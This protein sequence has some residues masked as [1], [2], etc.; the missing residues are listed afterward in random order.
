MTYLVTYAQAE[1][2]ELGRD[3][4]AVVAE[5]DELRKVAPSFKRKVAGLESHVAE[6]E[7]ENDR[8]RLVQ[9]TA[10]EKNREAV[11]E[12]ER[13]LAVANVAKAESAV[14]QSSLHT[15]TSSAPILFPPHRTDV[16]CQIGWM[17]VVSV[18][19]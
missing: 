8:L 16:G 12:L 2:H 6:L 3:L 19:Q 10:G 11:A 4:A 18:P 17:L 7:R 9:T 1:L 13:L 15:C 14:S 5:R